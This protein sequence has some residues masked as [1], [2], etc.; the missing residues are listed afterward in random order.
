MQNKLR[1]HE[2]FIGCIFV[3][4]H[5]GME[6]N[7]RGTCILKVRCYNVKI[8]PTFLRLVLLTTAVTLLIE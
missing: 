8:S 5:N 4:F 6:F 7:E 1:C 2:A 3:I